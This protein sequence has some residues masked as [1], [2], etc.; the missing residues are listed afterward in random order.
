ML[1]PIGDAR[2]CLTTSSVGCGGGG[3]GLVVAFTDRSLP[4][5]GSSPGPEAAHEGAAAAG[6][7]GE[8]NFRGGWGEPPLSNHR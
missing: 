8:S 7:A 1:V 3:E 4:R 6:V 5:P 2:E